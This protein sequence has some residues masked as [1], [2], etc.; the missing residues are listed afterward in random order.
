M[1]TKYY[2]EITLLG[3]CGIMALCKSHVSKYQKNFYNYSYL[4]H[5]SSIKFV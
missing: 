2:N 4:W 1:F 5:F 3:L